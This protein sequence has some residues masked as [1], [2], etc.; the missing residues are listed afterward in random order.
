MCQLV[1]LEAELERHLDTKER[2]SGNRKNGKTSKEVR[3]SSCTI[4]VE[5]PRDR[6]SAFEPELIRKRETILAE[7]LEYKI[8]GI[9]VLGMSLK[10]FL[11]TSRIFTIQISGTQFYWPLQQFPLILK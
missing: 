6:S 11:S 9:H 5:S 1:N 3:T 7:S 8:I 4:I 10:I 2:L